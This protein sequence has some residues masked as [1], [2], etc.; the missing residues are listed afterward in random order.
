VGASASA[1]VIG[2]GG[3]SS[4]E[5]SNSRPMISMMRPIHSPRLMSAAF[6]IV[7]LLAVTPEMVTRIPKITDSAR[8]DRQV[9]RV[10]GALIPHLQ[11]NTEH[12]NKTTKG[13]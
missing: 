9:V 2:A 1:A 7:A 6:V 13:A 12:G 4:T 3:F 8:L 10:A 5:V 11:Q